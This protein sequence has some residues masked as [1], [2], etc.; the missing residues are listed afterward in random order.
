MF[1]NNIKTI[2]V[3]REDID[4]G[5]RIAK[6]SEEITISTEIRISN[7]FIGIITENGNVKRNFYGQCKINKESGFEPSK[8]YEL[9]VIDINTPVNVRWGGAV[10]F[11]PSDYPFNMKLKCHGTCNFSIPGTGGV[12]L[13]NRLLGGKGDL[14]EKGLEDFLW[15]KINEGIVIKEVHKY[16]NETDEDGKPAHRLQDIIANCGD[17]VNKRFINAY[18]N[19]FQMEYGLKVENVRMIIKA[20]GNEEVDEEEKK[21]AI[22]K[23]QEKTASLI[24]QKEE[25][26]IGLADK[27][28]NVGKTGPSKRKPL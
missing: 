14:L 3:N 24:C 28:A 20:E 17:V 12:V 10:S 4:R 23:A 16:C 8:K 18:N 9:Y 19:F 7:S 5:K 13:Y 21:Q 1:G 15:N 26:F 11:R 2:C 6:V 22:L 25:H 27:Y